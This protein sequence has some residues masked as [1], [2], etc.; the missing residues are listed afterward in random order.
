LENLGR[1]M[2]KRERE[3]GRRKKIREEEEE[4]ERWINLLENMVRV[5]RKNDEK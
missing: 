1:V 5:M 2:G 3:G 4:K